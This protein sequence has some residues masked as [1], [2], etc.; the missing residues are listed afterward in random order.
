M[1]TPAATCDSWPVNEFCNDIPDDVTEEVRDFWILVASQYLWAMTGRRI[2]PSCPITVRP[3][4][5]GC[6]DGIGIFP[7]FWP[8]GY[9]GLPWIPY[10]GRDGLMYNAS[11]CGCKNDCHCGPELCDIRL[12]GPVYDVV[13]VDIDGAD[14]D[15]DTYHVYGDG[16]LTRLTT[17]MAEDETR[18]W[19]SCQDMTLP[20]GE[21]NTFTV[22]YRTGLAVPAAG[23]AAVS[24][25]AAHLI[26]GCTGGGC[27]CGVGT[28]QNLQSLTRQGV[29]LEFAD[30]QQLFTD[31]RTGIEIVDFFIK[32][33]NPY[34]LSSPMRVL[35]P[36]APKFPRVW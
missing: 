36:D 22:V 18:C 8:A 28:R 25:L 24:A 27:G 5:K 26:K 35:S 34:G 31:G 12:Q 1:P 13:S 16:R 6:A 14:V 29:S 11:L 2:G 21:V 7:G 33:T 4:R 30:P 32:M 15:P 20:P 3:C 10:V 9:S 19:P 17:D 23:I